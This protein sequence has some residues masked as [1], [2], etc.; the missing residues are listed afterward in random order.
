[1]SSSSL[2]TSPDVNLSDINK[3]FQHGLALVKEAV[4]TELPPGI[5]DTNMAEWL[6]PNNLLN[7]GTLQQRLVMAAKET[8][9]E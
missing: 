8:A 7:A 4:V 2:Y 6:P 1:M 3:I 5:V 9:Y